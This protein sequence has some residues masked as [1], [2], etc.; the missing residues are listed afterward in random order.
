M[1]NR[2]FDSWLSGFRESIA[3]Y[4][5]YINFEKVHRNV[6]NIKVELKY[7]LYRQDYCGCLFSKERNVDE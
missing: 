2:D 5:Y 6:D 4:G 3:D 1:K 7:N